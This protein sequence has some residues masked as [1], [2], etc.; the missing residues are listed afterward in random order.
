G[1]AAL[2]GMHGFGPHVHGAPGDLDLSFNGTGYKRIIVPGGYDVPTAVAVQED[3]KTVVVGWT[4]GGLR[5]SFLVRFN[6]DGTPDATFGN[7]GKVITNVAGDNS[8][9]TGVK[10]LA[11]GKIVVCG[12]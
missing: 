3:G 1:A 6:T 7:G 8:R 4:S 9:A 10:I 2:A 5:N 12:W 11:D